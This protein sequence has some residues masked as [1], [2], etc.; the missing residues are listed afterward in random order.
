MELGIYDI[1][2]EL[3][4]EKVELNPVVF[5]SEINKSLLHQAVKVYLA[6]QRQGNAKAKG[7]SEVAG[8]KAKMFAQK[9]TGRARKG[10]KRSPVLVGGGKVFGPSPRSYYLGMN[11][12][13]KKLARRSAFSVKAQ[14]NAIYLMDDFKI[15]TPKTKVFAEAFE[16]M[17]VLGKKI[18]V[19]VDSYSYLDADSKYDSVINMLKSVRNIKNVRCQ[20]ADTV[21]TYEIMNADYLVV[22]KNALK[23]IDR[24]SG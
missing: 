9:G 24:I 7:R 8:S 4:S 13:Q 20:V 6:N 19:L 15:E 12:K 16:K 11:Q 5:E 1:K 22:Q 3:T 21:S 17:N 18:L 10:G 2:G 23:T 14:E